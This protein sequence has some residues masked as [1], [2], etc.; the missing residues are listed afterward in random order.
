MLYICVGMYTYIHD[1]YPII[2]YEMAGRVRRTNAEIDNAVM[3]QLEKLVTQSG[4][5]NVLVTELMANAHLEPPV[6]YRRYGSIDNLYDRLAQRYDFWIN[7]TIDT[8]ELSALG[9]K[10]FFAK[11][12]KTLY[13][14][15]CNNAVMQK[16]LLWEM[17]AD[18]ET[19]RRTAQ[20]RDLMNMNLVEYYD[21]LFKP[22]HINIRSIIA[23]L[24]SGVYYLILHKERAPFCKIDFDTPEGEAA[25]S[26]A[27]DALVE[28]LFD[29]IE[30]HNEKRACYERM[31]KDG[32]SKKKACQYL[33]VDIREFDC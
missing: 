16:L 6:F 23:L 22:A 27:V 8:S 1:T 12:L 13:R 2:C 21:L 32:I 10:V 5:G 3:T 17:S 20:I 31:L 19:T 11:T 14:E 7:N 25:F 29:R 15:L 30:V 18:N 28:M 9:P 26:E 4:F 33:G 24:I